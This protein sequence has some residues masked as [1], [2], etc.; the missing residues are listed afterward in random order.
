MRQYP[1]KGAFW[2]CAWSPDGKWVAGATQEKAVHIWEAERAEHLHMPGYPAKVKAMGWT[3]D[4][5]WLITAAGADLLLWDCSGA[6]PCGRQPKLQAVHAVGIEF[7][8]IQKTG[9]LFATGDE[10]GRLILW[11]AGLEG[12]AGLMA[13][14]PGQPSQGLSAAAWSPDGIRLA[15][16][17][18]DGGLLLF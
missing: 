5:Q 6:G 4:G 15:V 11:D 1:W 12:D 2:C 18:T 9:H 7:S 14:Y 10:E 13:V 17:Q 3:Q 16:G 8:V